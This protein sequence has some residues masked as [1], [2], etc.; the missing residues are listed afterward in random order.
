MCS[1]WMSTDWAFAVSPKPTLFAHKRDRPRENID[2][3]A[4]KI[5]FDEPFFLFFFY[6]L[7][8]FFFSRHGWIIIA[9]NKAYV[10]KEYNK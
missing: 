4:L 2:E 6:F 3:A 8:I 10:E 5:W 9:Y 1:T 7:F